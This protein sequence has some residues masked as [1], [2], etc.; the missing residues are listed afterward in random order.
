MCHGPI[1]L[2]DRGAHPGP[3][4]GQECKQQG[5]RTSEGSLTST[6]LGTRQLQNFTSYLFSFS[7]VWFRQLIAG[8]HHKATLTIL[9]DSCH[10]G[11]LIDQEKEQIGPRPSTSPPKPQNKSF[12]TNLN[13]K[14]I[15]F[16]SVL[17]LQQITGVATLNT[18]N[19]MISFRNNVSPCCG[20]TFPLDYRL[21]KAYDN[22]ILLSGCQS[23]ECSEEN[24]SSKPPHG[25]FSYG[26]MTVLDNIGRQVSNKQI[27]M[28]TRELLHKQG[29][30]QHPCLY[31]IDE[32]ANATF[33][34][35]RQPSTN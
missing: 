4:L 23:D 18:A 29:D 32:N 3:T 1:L 25:V 30:R 15:P 31:C 2:P 13:S 14:F 26:V 11:G 8:I 5:S 19:H 27:V 10:S 21:D 22:G 28:L 24:K 7:D 34:M 35:Q 17:H 12:D 16:E 6:F 33:L 20:A 9:S